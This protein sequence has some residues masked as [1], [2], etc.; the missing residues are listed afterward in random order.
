[1]VNFERQQLDIIPTHRILKSK[2]PIIIEDDVW[3]GE[4]FCILGNATKRVDNKCGICRFKSTP[5]YSLAVGTPAK[6]IK[7]FSS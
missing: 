4:M 6:V 3:I 1:M 5:P 2:G 7:S